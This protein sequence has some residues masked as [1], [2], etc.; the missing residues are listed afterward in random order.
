MKIV[1]R[2]VKA[3]H[4]GGLGHVMGSWCRLGVSRRS[5]SKEVLF[6]MRFAG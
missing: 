5:F 3:E 4:Q 6:D 1:A 2:A